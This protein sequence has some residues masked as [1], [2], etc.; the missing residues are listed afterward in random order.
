MTDAAIVV[1]DLRVLRGGREVLPGLSMTVPRGQVVGLLGPSGGGKSTL[2]RALVGVQVVAGGTVSVLGAP[3]GSASLRRRVGYLTQAPSVYAD[4]TVRD[5]VRY[6]A[7]VL[8]ADATAVERAIEAV[9]LSDHAGARVANLSGGQLSRT[10]LACTLVGDPEVLVLDE[11]TV[12]LDP[13]LRREL[14]EIFRGLAAEGRTLVVSSH[15]M[16]EAVRCDRLL[17]LRAGALL[18]DSTLAELLA[19]TGTE[20][21][22]PAFLAL[23]DAAEDDGGS[24]RGRRGA[25]AEA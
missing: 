1:E 7:A 5:N 2:M 9:H 10:S 18:S 3:A 12:G 22:E 11:P 25:G 23:I 24:G 15:V 20:D 17:L 8:G 13:V 21:A 4:L 6:F 14:W 19:R 16:D